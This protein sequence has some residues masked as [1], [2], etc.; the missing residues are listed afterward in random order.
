MV[1]LTALPRGY[2]STGCTYSGFLMRDQLVAQECLIAGAQR[3]MR[4]P[5][6]L[7]MPTILSR[8]SRE[9]LTVTKEVTPIQEEPSCRFQKLACACNILG[10]SFIARVPYR[11]FQLGVLAKRDIASTKGRIPKNNVKCLASRHRGS[12]HI[13]HCAADPVLHTM[14]RGIH[15]DIFY[16]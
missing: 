12:I 6:Y 1:R 8:D 11:T 16:G 7:D 10:E 14:A 3:E 15:I 4:L 9:K 5:I 2:V 13:T